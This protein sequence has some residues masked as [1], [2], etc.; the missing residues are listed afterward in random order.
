MGECVATGANPACG[1]GTIVQTRTCTDGTFDKCNTDADIQRTVTCSVAGVSL[2]PCGGK[3][4][5]TIMIR[6]LYYMNI[7]L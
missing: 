3:S 5:I 4:K 1:P 2:P 6:K 7:V